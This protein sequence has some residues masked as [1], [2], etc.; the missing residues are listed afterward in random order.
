VICTICLAG[1]RRYTFF[2]DPDEESGWYIEEVI[3]GSTIGEVLA[4]DAVG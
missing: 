3:E 1:S 4:M 2:L